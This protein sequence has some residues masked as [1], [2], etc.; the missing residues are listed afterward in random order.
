MTVSTR[1]L[2]PNRSRSRSRRLGLGAYGETRHSEAGYG[3]VAGVPI[4]TRLSALYRTSQPGYAA[5][6][7]HI[8]SAA[9]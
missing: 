9:G 8:A 4:H 6:Q 7:R 2:S 1:T 3:P 5:W